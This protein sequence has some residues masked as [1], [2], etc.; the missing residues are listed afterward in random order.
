MDTGT[1]WVWVWVKFYTHGYGYRQKFVPID[2]T[3]MGMVL[4]Y[5]TRTVPIAIYRAAYLFASGRAENASGTRS[6][7]ATHSDRVVR[8]DASLAQICA[9]DASRW[10]LRGRAKCPLAFGGC[11]VR[12]S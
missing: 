11:F 3:G 1:R 7:G 4:L 6:S 5:S 8:S 9:S 10:T 12:P 2:Y